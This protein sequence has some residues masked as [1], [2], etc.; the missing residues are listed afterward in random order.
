MN[1]DSGRRGISKESESKKRSG[2]KIGS[3]Q[4]VLHRLGKTRVDA[5]CSSAPSAV[6]SRGTALVHIFADTHH[7]RKI[8]HRRAA[9]LVNQEAGTFFRDTRTEETR[10]D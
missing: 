2:E 10:F 6:S 7:L 5:R 8:Q 4:R 1:P 3:E 9:E